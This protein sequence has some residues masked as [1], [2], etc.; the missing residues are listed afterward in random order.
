MRNLPLLAVGWRAA[1]G[2]RF[3]AEACGFPLSDE[4]ALDK[5]ESGQLKTAIVGFGAA[6]PA[7]L[8]VVSS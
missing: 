6:R 8:A 7:A 5:S 3:R 4:R 1:L 2:A